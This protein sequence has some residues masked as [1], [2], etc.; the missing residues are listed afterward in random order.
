MHGRI[1]RLKLRLLTDPAD[2]VDVAEAVSGEA[3]RLFTGAGDELGLAHAYHLIARVNWVLSRALE[4]A[5]AYA[6][7]LEHAGRAGARVLTGRTTIEQIGSL[8]YGPVSRTEIDERVAR[9]RERDSV[10]ARIAVVSLEADLCRRDGRTTEALALADE[11]R[12]LHH[13]LGQELGVAI[14]MQMRAETLLDAERFDEAV[15][16]YRAALAKLEALGMDGF[17]STTLIKLGE[18]LYRG[19]DR[20]EAERA[21]LEGES[22]GAPEDVIN[23]TFGPA[24]RARIAADRGEHDEAERLAR[25]ALEQAYKTD[26]PSAH[27]NAHEALA[28]VLRSAGR[29]DEARDELTRGRALAALRPPHPRGA[30]APATGRAVS[31][32]RGGRS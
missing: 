4:S 22:L 14:A 3:V 16:E 12:T 27:A 21:A 8:L 17:R 18:G 28:W 5:E 10:L 23:S 24:L 1:A 32:R 20:A 25:H 31:A 15:A 19:G 30:R 2:A 6:R 9:L 13:E 26:F 29:D 7:V 11:A